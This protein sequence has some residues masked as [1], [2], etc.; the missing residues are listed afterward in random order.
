MKRE[1]AWRRYLRLRGPDPAADLDDELTHHLERR[2][3]EYVAAGMSPD[4]ARRAARERLGDLDDVRRECGDI[5]RRVD[6]RRR[7]SEWSHSLLTELRQAARR[8]RRRPG[9]ALAAVLTLGLGIGASTA[10]FAIVNGVLLKPLPFEDPDDLVSVLHTAPA[11]GYEEVLQATG[12]YFTYRTR[13]EV[14]EDVALWAPDRASVTG[15]AD[16]EVVDVLQVTDGLLPLLRVTPI[17]G[18]RFLPSDDVPGAPLTAMLSEGF[19]RSRYGG[20]ESAIG[21][22]IRV[23]GTPREIIGVV[24][25]GFGI[26]DRRPDVLTPFRFDPSTARVTDFS[27][28]GVARLLPG[29][30]LERARAE[31]D[32]LF[33]RAFEDYP[34]GLT[35]DIAREAGFAPVVEYMKERAVGDVR[36]V[37]WTLLGTVGLVLLI[38]CA[39]V[40]GLFLVRGEGQQQEVAVRA[41]LGAGRRAARGMALESW[42]L[43]LAGG[44]LGLGVAAVGV[45][46]LVRMGPATLP[47]LGGVSLEPAVI[48]LGLALA[49]AAAVALGTLTKRRFG[50]PDL[51]DALRASGRGASAT[52][53]RQRLR[54]ALVVTQVALALVLL[55]GAGL[56]MRSL[57]ALRDVEPGFERPGEVL[58]F[59]VSIPSSEEP[60]PGGVAVLHRRLLESVSTVPGITSAALASHLPMAGGLRPEDVV[61]LEDFPDPPGANP[62]V[63]RTRWVSGDYFDTMENPVLAGR[64]ITWEDVE[65][66]ANVV[67][68]TEDLALRYW[69]DVESALGSRLRNSDTADWREIVG[70]VGSV[71]DDGPDQD[72]VGLVYWPQVQEEFWGTPVYTPRSMSFVLRM[73]GIDP[74]GAAG[75]VRQ[76]VW[77][78]NANLPLARVM[79]LESIVRS[80]V[81]RTSF[82][83][84]LLSIAAGVAL[85]LG[86]IGLYGVVSYAVATRTREIGVRIALGAHRREVI[87]MV[88]GQGA[89]LA[90]MGL[91]IGFAAAALAT[92]VLARL[93]YGVSPADPPTYAATAAL[94]GLVAVVA[95]WLPARRAARI[96]PTEALRHE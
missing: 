7:R 4:A 90:L 67:V 94:L 68:I 24:P 39:N 15:L 72:P 55:V 35:L 23:N 89:R 26:V 69:G 63:H 62:K 66:R 58:T 5:A 65:A 64:P 70:V 27:Y 52:R 8:L 74:T 18:R 79:T 16:P 85:A 46:A 31:L 82:T 77:E 6:R 2:T 14:F 44:L 88:V 19:W 53:G 61:Y 38:A 92:R 29:V 36:R 21:Q 50:R 17:V 34:R 1:P 83:V 41:A 40:A 80:A 32:A 45:R 3:E 49:V 71:H 60:D 75:G 81:S 43:G 59:E 95:S 86:I 42:I 22:S 47:R 25:D 13:N 12:T 91:A 48:L 78:V 57:A 33:P 54:S 11:L 96:E 56:M 84:T 87:G 73:P 9:F 28:E 51:Q 30:T 37:L 10:I 20:D 93:L 76:A